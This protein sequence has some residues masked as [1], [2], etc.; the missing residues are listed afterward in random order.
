MLSAEKVAVIDVGSN[1]CRMVIYEQAGAALLPYFNEKAMVGLGRDMA[2]TGIIYPA[3]KIKALETL[4]RFQAILNGLGIDKV[5][6]VATSAVREA[7]DGAQFR[8]EAEATLGVPLQVLSGADE[9]RISA[10]GVVTGFSKAKG[11][12]ADLGGASL[13]LQSVGKPAGD[14]P[15]ETYLLGPLARAE[16]AEL[17]TS[18][19]RK[20]IAKIL[21]ESQTLPLKSGCLY[22]VG[23]AWRNVAAVHMALTDYPLG[24]MHAYSL[25]RA[26]LATVI[27]AAEAAHDDADI[28]ERLQRVAKRRY[29][30]L[31]HAALVLDTLLDLSA[32]SAAHISA[33]GLREGV[34]AEA[35]GASSGDGL[36]DTAQ[37][38][39]KLSDASTAFGHQVHTFIAPIL[40]RI[41]QR[42]AVLSATC[43]MADA[44]ARLHPDHRSDLI[45]EQ[46][47]R[48]P[49][50]A[51][52]HD[53]RV[54]AAFAVA[55]RNT[56]KFRAPAAIARIVS[57]DLLAQARLVGT[58]MRLAGVY[59][60]RSAQILE[61]AGLDV[62]PT[63]L[64]LR[65]LEKNQDMVSGTVR[66]R[67][68]QLAGL[69]GLE[70]RIKISAKA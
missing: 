61:T 62:T 68:Q 52:G 15:G 64:V 41:A 66:R 50:P 24:V 47:L 26:A 46:V 23:G 14:R 18:K 49:L 38:Y 32:V 28:R 37:L 70:A 51:I 56:F 5:Y 27:E 6:A 36:L 63:D 33:Y 4:Q 54:F 53:E 10:L 19:R 21:S 39:L 43:M 20:A 30:T 65:V 58:A 17:A 67:H 44:G 60:G 29:E 40:N 13:E 55:S 12:V 48:A 11:L 22:A 7:S 16:D 8:R 3:G 25:D 42:P 45:F 1:S 34:V 57:P 31:L 35:S 69:M 59:S 2:K 9:G